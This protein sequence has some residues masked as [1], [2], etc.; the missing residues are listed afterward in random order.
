[1]SFRS[2]AFASLFLGLVVGC[3]GSTDSGGTTDQDSGSPADS[4]GGDT[5]KGDTT[6]GGDTNPGG[7]TSSGTDTKTGTDTTPGDG[8]VACGTTTC[9]KGQVCCATPGDGGATFTCAADCPDGSVAIRCLGSSDCS[10][11]TKYCCGTVT[12]DPSTPPC[13]FS[14]GEASC[15]AAC[16]T[17]IPTSCDGKTHKARLCNSVADCA[18]D[19]GYTNCCTFSGGGTTGQVCAND[20]MKA[21]ADSCL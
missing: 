1:M 14:A 19:T 21:F 7:D 17:E 15:A 9:D 18:D 8:G 13:G 2:F 5:N 4:S 16:Q 20:I 6:T 12:L 10:G 3:G 11:S